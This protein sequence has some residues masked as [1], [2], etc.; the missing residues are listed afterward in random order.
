MHLSNILQSLEPRVNN[1]TNPL[2]DVSGVSST[3]IRSGS[4]PS[5]D[6]NT[7]V[8]PSEAV[9]LFVTFSDKEPGG[10]WLCYLYLGETN[11]LYI[12]CCCYCDCSLIPRFT[13]LTVAPITVNPLF[14]CPYIVDFFCDIDTTHLINILFHNNDIY[15][16]CEF[17]THTH[18]HTHRV[19]RF[20]G[21]GGFHRF[22][23]TKSYN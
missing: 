23:N 12:P 1:T 5:R 19:C 17:H 20:A 18:A 15:Q 7:E 21:P 9:C 4:F 3:A 22:V 16:Y 6:R 14:C 13:L 2:T 8:V 10:L 11:K